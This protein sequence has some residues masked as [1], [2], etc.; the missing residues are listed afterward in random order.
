MHG[1]CVAQDCES[2]FSPSTSDQIQVLR[3]GGLYTLSRLIGPAFLKSES[4]HVCVCVCA[5]MHVYAYVCV[6]MCAWC[7]NMTAYTM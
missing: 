6:F 4:V 3:L 1:A 2:Q 7:V 5:C